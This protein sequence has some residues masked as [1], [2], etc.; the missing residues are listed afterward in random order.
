M[1]P[2]NLDEYYKNILAVRDQLKSFKNSL[3]E[4]GADL[5]DVTKEDLMG[6]GLT[7]AQADYEINR[8]AKA[9]GSFKSLS[10]FDEASV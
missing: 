8:L 4:D 9:K 5:K 2:T 10:D 7:E 3:Q 6:W 1:K